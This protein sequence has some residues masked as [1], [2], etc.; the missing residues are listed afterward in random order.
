MRHMN[1]DED[2]AALVRELREQRERRTARAKITA[3]VVGVVLLLGIPIGLKVNADREQAR[4][5]CEVEA[6][7]RGMT[8]A[9]ARDYCR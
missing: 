7:M 8:A 4:F 3:L 9:E 2:V 6:T 1:D 5:G